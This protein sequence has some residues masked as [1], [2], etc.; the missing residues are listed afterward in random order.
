MYIHYQV[1]Q[2]NKVQY[3]GTSL[4]WMASINGITVQLP[5]CRSFVSWFLQ[6]MLAV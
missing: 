3:H 5:V 2:L 4:Y 6:F 1:I